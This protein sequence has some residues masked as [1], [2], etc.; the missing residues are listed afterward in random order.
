VPGEF[1]LVTVDDTF[2]ARTIHP[3][4]TALHIPLDVMGARG[5]DLLTQ[6][7]ENPDSEPRHASLPTSLV[8]RASTAR[9]GG[10]GS[11]SIPAGTS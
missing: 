3:A 9:P 6:R 2:M 5:V 1:S 4:L 10:N 8:V 7:I 11:D